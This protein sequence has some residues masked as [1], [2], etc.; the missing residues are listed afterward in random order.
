MHTLQGA[1]IQE[2]EDESVLLD[3]NTTL[4]P[5]GIMSGTTV[6]KYFTESIELNQK[7]V[8]TLQ[9]ILDFK[10][11]YDYYELKVFFIMKYNR[12]IWEKEDLGLLKLEYIKSH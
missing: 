10:S 11:I 9:K 6:R 12:T 1:F 8:E 2:Y 3:A 4:F 5:F 7:W